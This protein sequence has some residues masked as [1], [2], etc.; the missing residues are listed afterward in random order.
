MSIIDD[1]SSKMSSRVS[2]EDKNI[3]IKVNYDEFIKYMIENG[4]VIKYTYIPKKYIK[5]RDNKII[6]ECLND[7]IITTQGIS[8]N[9]HNIS[10]TV[11][12]KLYIT[13]SSLSMNDEIKIV[14]CESTIDKISPIMKVPYFHFREKIFKWIN[15]IYLS[16]NRRV[17]FIFNKDIRINDGLS[18]IYIEADVWSKEE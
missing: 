12:M 10:Y 9:I 3:T 18:E 5:I 1:I 7:D 16:K 2:K 8:Q 17:E 4:Y 14:L 13:E 15:G 11:Y 6:L